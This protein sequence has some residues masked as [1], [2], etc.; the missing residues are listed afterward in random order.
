MTRAGHH[1]NGVTKCTARWV[2]RAPPSPHD[3]QQLAGFGG[4]A[5][6]AY[7]L[8]GA[9]AMPLSAPPWVFRLLLPLLPFA[10]ACGGSVGASPADAAG[11]DPAVDGGRSADATADGPAVDAGDSGEW[12]DA[13]EAGMDAAEG[14]DADL[15]QDG[16]THE[17]GP[18]V[19]VALGGCYETCTRHLSR[20]VGRRPST[21]LRPDP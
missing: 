8:P 15:G 3:P 2:Q 19:A 14:G 18:V 17:A 4:E 1:G 16:A 5:G 21:G 7:F 11:V 6:F 20:W 10:C 12:T 9:A 13:T